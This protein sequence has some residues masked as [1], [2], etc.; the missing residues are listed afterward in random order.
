MRL[1]ITLAALAA[2]IAVASPAFAQTT[3]TATAQARGVVLLP[4]TI[5]EV[6]PLNFGTVLASGVAGTVTIDADTGARSFTGGVSGIALD[7]GNR[8][9]FDGLGTEN[10]LVEITLN[11]VANL[12]G[13][14]PDIAV[15]SMELDGCACLIE[16]RTIPV[17]GGGA[18]QVGV[19]GT[20][21]IAAS[22]PNGLY[23]G[24]YSVTA[25]YQ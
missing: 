22:Q 19:G 7:L 11:P 6:D 15:T 2:S 4:L 8:G 24:A 21:A 10:Q 13:P 16:T 18:F 25:E 5:S 12:T 3:D 14:G 23:T 17:G 9:L 1:K 20:F